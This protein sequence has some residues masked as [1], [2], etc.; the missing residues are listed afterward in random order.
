MA[1]AVTVFG[2]E[3]NSVTGLTAWKVDEE[4]I[5]Q[6]RDLSSGA[7]TQIALQG[8]GSYNPMGSRGQN[9]TL[10]SDE[11]GKIDGRIVSTAMSPDGWSIEANS[12][13]HV[14]A[15]NAPVAPAFNQ[16]L[17]QVFTHYGRA[18]QGSLFTGRSVVTGSLANQR[19]NVP[20]SSGS[21]WQAFKRFL[22]A[23]E[24]DIYWL[25]GAAHLVRMGDAKRGDLRD[26]AATW[27][28]SEKDHEESPTVSCYVHHRE[29]TNSPYFANWDVVYPPRKT[30]YPTSTKNKVPLDQELPILTVGA[31]EVTVQTLQ[32]DT[33]L[34]GLVQPQMVDSI[35]NLVNPMQQS[36]VGVFAVVGTDNRPIT[37]GMW[38]NYGGRLTVAIDKDD[39]SR[40]EITLNGPNI[41]W[42]GPFRIAESDGEK[43]YS[44][45]YIVGEGDRVDIE[46]ITLNTAST[47]NADPVTIDNPAIDTIDKGYKAMQYT[48][49]RSGGTEVTMS[50]S[51]SD[52]ARDTAGTDVTY[53]GIPSA[54][55]RDRR[56]AFGRIAGRR[57]RGHDR[58]WRCQSASIS[59]QGVDM[60]LEPGDTLGDLDLL[61]GT[62]AKKG[63]RLIGKTL[64]RL[65]GAR[66]DAI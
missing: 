43:D 7:V 28:I 34:R 21:V 29:K 22:S 38:D 46:E 35:N 63:H 24:I 42:L 30:F 8:G 50:W 16:T 23:N 60:T 54:E 66:L 18:A 1:V 5:S 48:A 2:D 14:L 3:I 9:L 13:M 4:A 49:D 64:G 32:L 33:E 51:G 15:V 27:T 55:S 37:R 41:P 25:D 20:A 47:S 53:S 17:S 12:V 6:D 36:V 45:L 39:P 61:W 58:F 52:P 26:I 19:F 57:F 65:S 62:P 40:V 11:Y 56:Q 44:A 31:N 10:I 59:E